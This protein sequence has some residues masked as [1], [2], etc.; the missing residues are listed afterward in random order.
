MQVY[1]CVSFL[2]I[3]NEQILLEKRSKNKACDP[4]LI[5]I[6]GGHIVPFLSDPDYFLLSTDFM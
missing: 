6:P 4:N 2:L 1:E 3:Q 5:A